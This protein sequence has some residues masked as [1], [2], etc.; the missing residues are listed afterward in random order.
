MIIGLR[1]LKPLI[2]VYTPEGEVEHTSDRV[3]IF[4]VSGKMKTEIQQNERER[5]SFDGPIPPA[6]VSDSERVCLHL[7][8]SRTPHG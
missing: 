5:K 8:L 1:T 7:S 6:G 3:V 2:F 4:I